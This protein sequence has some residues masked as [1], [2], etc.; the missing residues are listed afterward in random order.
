MGQQSRNCGAEGREDSG[1]CVQPG[2]EGP[3]GHLRFYRSE[4]CM[5]D[6]GGSVHEPAKRLVWWMRCGT[7]KQLIKSFT[8]KEAPAQSLSTCRTGMFWWFRP[9]HWVAVQTNVPL[10]T[11]PGPRLSGASSSWWTHVFLL[12]LGHTMS[13]FHAW[14][15]N[16]VPVLTGKGRRSCWL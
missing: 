8:G 16:H 6:G 1:L 11:F 2:A 3:P 5:S 15:L 10:L 7:K 9:G 14:A 4:S 12:A 13:Q